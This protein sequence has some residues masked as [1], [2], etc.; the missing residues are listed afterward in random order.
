MIFRKSYQINIRLIGVI[1]IIVALLFA[2]A[3]QR[4]EIDFDVVN[5]LPGNDPVI[6][7]AKYVLKNHP[8][9]DQV[10][11]DIANQSKNPDLLVEGGDFVVKGL[12]KSGLFTDIGFNE[13]QHLI[14]ELVSHVTENLPVMFTARQLENELAPLVDREAIRGKLLEAVE[15]LVNLE[16]IGQEKLISM[17]PLG[18]RF[19]VLKKMSHLAPANGGRIYRGHLISSDNTHLLV[20]ANP[21]N[22]GTDTSFARSVIQLMDKL[23]LEIN[24]SIENQGEPFKVTA[25]GAYRAALD[26]EEIVKKDT[27]QAIVFASIGIALLLLLIFPRPL[28]G[29][30]S[31]IPAFF[32]I[33]S[34]FTIFSLIHP[35]ISILA[36]GFGGAIISISVDHGIAYFLFFDRSINTTGEDAAREV[37]A[38]GWMPVLTTVG[39]FWVLSFSGFPILS[40]IG[41]FAA[42][43]ILSSFLFIHTLLPRLFPKIPP[44]KKQKLNYMQRL[45]DY[46]AIRGG[47]P[48]AAIAFLVALTMLFFAKPEFNTDLKS[49]NTISPGT[50]AAEKLISQV[51]G[52][53]FSK[54]YLMI[55]GDDIE[56]LQRKSDRV[57]SYLEEDSNTEVVAT[58]FASSMI[59]PGSGLAGKNLSAWKTFWNIKRKTE[60]KKIIQEISSEVGFTPQAFAPFFKLLNGSIPSSAPLSG[61]LLNLIGISQKRGSNQWIQFSSV[62]P[63]KNYQSNFFY[64]RYSFDE[65]IKVFDA[66][67]FSDRFGR[68]LV[69]TFLKMLLI[70]S[71][72]VIIL[73][74]V[75]FLDW[76]LTVIS[77]LP[78]LFAMVCTLGT[79]KILGFPLGIPAVML[80]IVVFGMGIDY[81]L[82]FVRS[83]Q[84]Y[85]EVNHPSL[86][87]VRMA[88]T[89][90]AF[91]TLIGFGVLAVSDHKLLKDAGLTSFLGIGFSV[92]GAYA[93][94]PLF[95]GSIFNNETDSAK[96]IGKKT[97]SRFSRV[98][99]RY[100]NLEAYPRMFARFKMRMDPMFQELAG[101]LQNSR[102]ILDIGCG[103]GVPAC[104][105]IESFPEIHVFGLDPAPGRIRVANR[106]MGDRGDA[107]QGKLPDLPSV[108]ETIDT[109]IMLDIVHYLSDEEWKASLNNLREQLPELSKVVIRVT[110]PGKGRTPW[111][112]W[113]EVQRIRWTR[114]RCYFRSIEAL[115]KPLE[116]MG[117]SIQAIE[118]SGVGREETWIV[119]EVLRK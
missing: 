8:V 70:V 104:W 40:Q 119:A 27:R 106:A 50:A 84:R 57:T 56:D 45:M 78:V 95:L 4:L 20:V 74:F 112:R 10:V 9:Q 118:P 72:S 51:W 117:L 46:L 110:I 30:L 105:L 53:I 54:V 35:S 55:E 31:L 17:D 115:K 116:E 29:L 90:A 108:P 26:N 68:L 75:F 59:Y 42:L 12:V 34:A 39:A 96:K 91:S 69:S 86:G 92:I 113:I 44:A 89:L 13:K 58:A 101:Y 77:L 65:D 111:W 41:Q 24:Q 25:V 11:I 18:F 76:R 64:R 3:W 63:G 99:N 109:V 93:I 38:I 5:S 22:S 28:I 60:I 97:E 114:Q 94:L 73:L 15:S 7:D 33:L 83:Y 6:T 2:V 103:I 79:L 81:S 14:P 71:V 85:G 87:L 98:L 48:K 82:F 47:K 43:G 102:L 37:W 80:A 67:Y 107:I 32:G 52:N 49:I 66:T 19:L 36:L 21:Q 16:G 100:R 1:A 62:T 23:S 61:D 88:V